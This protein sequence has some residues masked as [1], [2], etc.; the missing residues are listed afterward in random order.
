MRN[1]IICNLRQKL[2]RISQI[3]YQK[4]FL[5]YLLWP[6]SLIY[7]GLMAVRH[8]LYR[9]GIIKTTY[10]KVRLIVIGNLTVGGTG[11]TPL[12]ISIVHW[13]QQQGWRPGLVSRGYGGRN[14]REVRI[15]SA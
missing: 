3:W 10:F 1:Y 7:K 12:V 6:F 8:Y 15:V 13:L 4:H 2:M 5:A 11:K 9:C 14:D